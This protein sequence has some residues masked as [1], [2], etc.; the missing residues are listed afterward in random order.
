[1][2]C[3]SLPAVSLLSAFSFLSLPLLPKCKGM[4]C[5]AAK[6]VVRGQAP[7]EAVGCARPKPCPMEAVAAGAWE[8]GKGSHGTRGGDGLPNVQQC[9]GLVR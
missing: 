6:R 5:E 4:W 2:R 1:V 8:E 7:Q 9:I 3:S